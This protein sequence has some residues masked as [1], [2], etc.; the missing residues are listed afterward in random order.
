MRKLFL[1][2]VFIVI[3][4]V[5]ASAQFQLGIKGGLNFADFQIDN[6][7]SNHKTGYHFG[8]FT[9]FKLGKIAVQPEV[10]FSQQGTE[11]NFNG[12]DLKSNFNYVNVPV[13][14]KFYLVGGLNL[15]VGPQFGFLTGATSSFDPIEEIETGESSIKD[16]YSES[17][18]SLGL[19]IGWDLPFNINLDFRYN[20]GL[21][22]I[23]DQN[24]PA[25]RNQ[26]YQ[27]SLGIR[28]ID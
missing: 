3:T 20:R 8:A 11:F 19:G 1:S 2:I 16:Y 15:Q 24:V 17:D 9:T 4:S 28:L 10:I 18:V 21:T 26:V 7:Q 27:I 13:I 23:S 22:D 5:A 12:K 25:T 14:F 6:I